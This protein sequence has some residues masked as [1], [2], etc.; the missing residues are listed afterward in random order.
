MWTKPR[1][2]R[3]SLTMIDGHFLCLSESGEFYLL[4]VNPNKYDEV[5]QMLVRDPDNNAPLLRS[6][7]WASP[8]V[9]HGLLYLR[10]K[11]RLVCLELIPS[12]AKP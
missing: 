9:S 4:K 6:P 8:V 12:K 1:M 5:S 7:C 3:C 2:G 10:G 11:G